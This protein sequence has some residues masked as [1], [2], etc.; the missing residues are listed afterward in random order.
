M[1]NISL[2]PGSDITLGSSG[3]DSQIDVSNILT[4]S[5]GVDAQRKILVV[6]A[7]KD[8]TVL[9]NVE[10]TNTNKA[11]DNALVVGAADNVMIDGAS[12]SY[13]GANLAIGAGDQ[14]SDSLWLANTSIT[15]G[16]NL[17]VGSLG[18][19]QHIEF[20]YCSRTIQFSSL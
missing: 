19:P 9:G 5:G 10:F 14:T 4:T 2:A 7:A 3:S 13:D 18:N 6:G 8:L 16:G 1:S 12:L 15:A 11:E 17:A 20:F